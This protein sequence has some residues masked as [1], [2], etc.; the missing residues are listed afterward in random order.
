MHHDWPQ[1]ILRRYESLYPRMAEVTRIFYNRL[2]ELTAAEQE[3]VLATLSEAEQ[4][5]MQKT[6]QAYE[7]LT[8]QQRA[9]C[10]RSFAKFA[11]LPSAERQEFLKN[12]E[13]WAQ[14][15]PAQRQSW[16]ELVSTAPNIPP[17]PQLTIQRPPP[18]PPGLRQ[19][20]TPPT[21]NGG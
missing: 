3:N 15:T 13:R 1:R 20:P 11:E 21:T 14:M 7:R 6:L 19:N 5:Q 18:L 2:F 17:L 16:R 9:Q 4:R 8:P 10:V 12:A